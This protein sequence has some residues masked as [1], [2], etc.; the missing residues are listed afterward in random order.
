M[1]EMSN[2]HG[3]SARYYDAIYAFKDYHHEAESIRWL[4]GARGVG[5]GATLLDVACGTGGHLTFLREHYQVEGL[6]VSPDM[7]AIARQRH[8]DVPLHHADM[9]DFELGRTFDAV[10]CLFSAIGYARTEPLMRQAIAR[11]ARHVRPGGALVV[12]PWFRPDQYFAGRV[13]SRYI[14]QRNFHVC[15]MNVS[16]VAGELSIMDMHYLIGTPD[17][18]DHFVERHELGLWTQAQMTDAFTAV[19][20]TVEAFDDGLMGR[21]LYV[22]RQ[23]GGDDASRP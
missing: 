14:D 8:P 4:L 23:P 20:M 12:E 3:R 9:L 15:R 18:V 6:D 7:L 17:G 11:M 22:A 1:T 21:G 10:I 2:Q 19:G 13:A 5:D 16:E